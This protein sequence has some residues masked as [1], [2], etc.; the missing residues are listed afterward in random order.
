MIVLAI[1][2]LRQA[3]LRS[4]ADD[5]L[6]RLRRYVSCDERELKPTRGRRSDTELRADE[7]ARLLGAVPPGAY[8]IALDERGRTPTSVELAELL[9]RQLDLSREIVLVVGGALGHHPSLRERADL[10]LAL[11]TLT[12]PHELARVVLYEQLYRAMTILRGEPYH[13]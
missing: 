10:V 4:V 11:S 5:Y 13:K 2:R 9:R 6:K 3:P 12:L 1:D 8:L 7:S